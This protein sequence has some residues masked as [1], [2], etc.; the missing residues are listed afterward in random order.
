[1][2]ENPDELNKALLYLNGLNIACLPRT[3]NDIVDFDGVILIQGVEK[4]RFRTSV[5]DYCTYIIKTKKKVP[6][7][8]CSIIE[9][10]SISLSLPIVCLFVLKNTVYINNDIRIDLKLGAVFNLT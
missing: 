7:K 5:Y 9:H 3:V 10:S 1:M 6:I 8:V 2:N 4:N